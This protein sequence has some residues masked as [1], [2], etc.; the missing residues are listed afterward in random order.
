[1]KDARAIYREESIRGATP[2]GMVILLYEQAVQDL[3]RALAAIEQNDIEQRT[4]E[5]N[6]AL[7]IIGH[8]QGTLDM[9]KGGVIALNLSQCYERFKSNLVAA[10]TR[11]SPEI[12]RHQITD[13]LE[14]R[15]AWL[16]VNRVLQQSNQPTGTLFHRADGENPGTRWTI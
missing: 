13:L 16:E 8:L 6:H 1:M 2:V 9:E 15:E 7:A 10:Q 4:Y 12:I 3:L 5:I 14:L 11:V